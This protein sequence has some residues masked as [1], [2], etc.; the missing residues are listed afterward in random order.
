MHSLKSSQGY[1]NTQ[2]LNLHQ[3][4]LIWKVIMRISAIETWYLWCFWNENIDLVAIS[5]RF[6]CMLMRFLCVWFLCF[7]LNYRV[8]S[9]ISIG[10]FWSRPP[11]GNFRGLHFGGFPGTYGHVDTGTGFEQISASRVWGNWELSFFVI[12]FGRKTRSE[13]SEFEN[14]APLCLFQAMLICE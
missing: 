7:P 2:N 3:L 9:R 5:E 13:C 1:G 8:Y 11:S 6:I 4:N 14:A 10:Y 12:F